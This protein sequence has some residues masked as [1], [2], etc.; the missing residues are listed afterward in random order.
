MSGPLLPVAC[1]QLNTR[2]DAAANLRAAAGLVEEAAAAGA[3]LIALPETWLYKG[4]GAGIRA[5]AEAVDGPGNA[6]LAQLAARFGVGLVDSYGAFKAVAAAGAPIAEYM[7]Q[8]NHP[9]DKGHRIVAS[10]ILHFFR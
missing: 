3:R 10:E 6:A 5:G 7:S 1:V 8:G 9:N 2:D 4:R